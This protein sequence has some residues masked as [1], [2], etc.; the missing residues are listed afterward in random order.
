MSIFA[1]LKRLFAGSVLKTSTISEETSTVPKAP[2]IQT[3][4]LSSNAGFVASFKPFKPEREN[5]A[6]VEKEQQEEWEE[7]GRLRHALPPG[8]NREALKCVG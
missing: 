4:V 1:S 7:F 6:W 3:P 2:V 5:A 8:T